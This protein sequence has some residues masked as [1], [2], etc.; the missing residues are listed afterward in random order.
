MNQAKRMRIDLY[1]D[2]GTDLCYRRKVRTEG[3]WPHASQPAPGQ[4]CFVPERWDWLCASFASSSDLHCLDCFAWGWE[5][6]M[7]LRG[8]THWEV[9]M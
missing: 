1:V 5:C 6:R 2:A 4:T 8:G 3:V 7:P 9:L